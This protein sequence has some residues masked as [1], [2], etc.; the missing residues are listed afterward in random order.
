MIVLRVLGLGGAP[1]G[2][3]VGVIDRTA[4]G[5]TFWEAPPALFGLVIAA[6]AAAASSRMSWTDTGRPPSSSSSEE[7]SSDKLLLESIS[8]SPSF[9]GARGV[10]A[11]S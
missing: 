5:P 3:S 11:W 1:A 6:A 10:L 4:D 9:A 7:S 8:L 2:A